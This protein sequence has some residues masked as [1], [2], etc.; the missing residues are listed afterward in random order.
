MAPTFVPS[1]VSGLAK[2]LV[3]VAQK[4]AM[5]Y[6]FEADTG[7]TFWTRSVSPTGLGAGLR[8]GIAVDHKAVYYTLPYSRVGYPNLFNVSSSLYG[9]ASLRDGRV[10]WER[11]ATFG[12]NAIALNAPTL[13]GD[14]V[15]VPRS[16]VVSSDGSYHNSR[17]ALVVLERESGKVVMERELE[18]NFQGGI[19]VVGGL[20]MFGTGYRN[21][22]VYDYRGNGSFHVWKVE[23]G[24]GEWSWGDAARHGKE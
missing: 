21:G 17:G 14:L 2:D 4:N 20:V 19:A 18:T 24:R 15:F 5:L 11:D 22:V 6:A 13:A 12:R 3:V 10:L 9:C 23:G 8:W 16:G 1:T 7:R